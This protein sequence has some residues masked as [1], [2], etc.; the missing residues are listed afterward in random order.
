MYKGHRCG[1]K[2]NLVIYVYMY[3]SLLKLKNTVSFEQFWNN[4]NQIHVKYWLKKFTCM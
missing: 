3:F 1:Q 2:K 4:Y